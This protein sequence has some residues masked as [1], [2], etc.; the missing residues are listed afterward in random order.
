MWGSAGHATAH[1][2]L[3][4][5]MLCLITDAKAVAAAPEAVELEADSWSKPCIVTH[6]QLMQCTALWGS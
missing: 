1:K 3:Q 5:W 4:S 6:Q 2:R